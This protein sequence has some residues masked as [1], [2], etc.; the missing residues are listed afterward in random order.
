MVDDSRGEAVR[1]R[2]DASFI[3]TAKQRVTRIKAALSASHAHKVVYELHAL[4]GEASLLQLPIADLAHRC[5]LA[6]QKWRQSGVLETSLVEL[7][8]ELAATLDAWPSHE[9]RTTGS[10]S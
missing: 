9:P 4:T 2:F 10:A 1:S 8:D 3:A 7:V 5:E 6:A